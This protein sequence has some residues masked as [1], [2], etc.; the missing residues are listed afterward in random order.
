[1]NTKHSL[2]GQLLI[3]SPQMDDPRFV[4]AVIL[5]CHHDETSAMGLIINH[6]A[7][8]MDLDELSKQLGTG[9]PRFGGDTPVHYGGPVEPSRGMVLHSS[10]HVLPETV[11]VSNEVAMTA[12]IRII[13]EITNGY[14]P[15]EFIIALGH[16]SWAAGQLENE[17]KSN[18]WIIMPYAHDLVFSCLNRDQWQDCYSRL[19]IATEHMSSSVGHA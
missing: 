13:S 9:T 15:S 6:K 19:G 4:N 1:M 17:L 2:L 7:D 8:G 14:G 16:A 11:M 10:D 5:I 12:N 3:A 18:A